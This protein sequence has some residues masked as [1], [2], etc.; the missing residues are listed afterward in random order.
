MEQGLSIMVPAFNEEDNLESTVREIKTGVRRK[1]K[2]CEIII[3][4][5]G[6]TDRT[7]EI[8]KSLAKKDKRIMVVHN[9]PNRGMGY[10][11]IKGQKLARFEHYMYIPGD[12]Q[13]PQTALGKMLDC[14]GEAD[15]IIPYVTNMHIR[16]FL[17]RLI[18]SAFTFLI[19]FLFGLRVRY[20][21]GPVIHK[22]ALLRAVPQRQNSGHAYQAEIIVRLIKAGASFVEVGFNMAERKGGITSAFRLK[23]VKMVTLTIFSLFWEIQVL[24]RPSVSPKVQRF[25][26]HLS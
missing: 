16:P 13:F 6:S 10:C 2:N 22:T 25:F 14:L 19:N 1:V 11:Y 7:G 24:G 3:F 12:N 9:N 23:R 18:S 8:A 4:N 26:Q 21:N 5:D 15:I 20:Y 17:R